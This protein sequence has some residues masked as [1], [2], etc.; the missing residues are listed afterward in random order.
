MLGKFSVMLLGLIAAC[1]VAAIPASKVPV[2]RPDSTT[3]IALERTV[4][5]P[6]W[7]VAANPRTCQRLCRIEVLACQASGQFGCDE[8]SQE[9]LAA[10]ML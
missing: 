2:P 7:Q 1:N 4:L 5:R 3:T 6:V 9:C 10:C 8:L